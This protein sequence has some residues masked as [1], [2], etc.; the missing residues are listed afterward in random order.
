MSITHSILQNDRGVILAVV[1]MFLVILAA[2]GSATVMMTRAEIK[3]GDNYK[4]NEQRIA[5]CII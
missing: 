3:T 2:M 4:N 1:L 5:P